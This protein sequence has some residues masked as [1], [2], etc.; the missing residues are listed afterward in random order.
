MMPN[1]FE[2]AQCYICNQV[3]KGHFDAP[4]IFC[5]LHRPDEV[6]FHQS[7]QAGPLTKDQKAQ[8]RLYENRWKYL[9]R[10]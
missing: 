7:L 8:R 3:Y 10:T 9:P 4:V 1:I 5:H 6:D 2:S